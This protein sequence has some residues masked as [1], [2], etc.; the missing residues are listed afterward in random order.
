MS[1]RVAAAVC[2]AAFLSTPAPVSA[3]PKQQPT[4]CSNATYL[5][6]DQR[7]T[8]LDGDD[9]ETP[10]ARFDAPLD[11]VAYVPA[12]GGFW[13]ISGDRVVSFDQTGRITKRA[14]LPTALR[15]RNATSAAA[16]TSDRWIVRTDREVVTYRMPALKE[17]D[18]H[19]LDGPGADILLAPRIAD[20][21]LDH[22]KLYTI[23]SGQLLRIDPRTGAATPI[24][25]PGGLPT[26]GTF[27][28]IVIDPQ[29]TL[30]AWHDQTG[31]R[32]D[33]KLSDPT[34]AKTKASSTPAA[35]ADAAACPEAW[36]YGD[37]RAPYPTSR[38]KN[39][40]RHRITDGLTL[41]RTVT[42]ET[43]AA[44]QDQDD[45]LA[46][47]ATVDPDGKLTVDITVTNQTGHN[48]LLAAWHDLDGNG[49]FDDRDVVTTTVAPGKK[50]RT[51]TL[52]WNAKPGTS[53][54]RIRLYGGPRG[55][56]APSP[57]PTGPAD[58]GEVEDHP[59]IAEPAPAS[60]PKK[61]KLDIQNLA[62]PAAAAPAV[63]DPGAKPEPVPVPF[64]E[65][66]HL[67]VAANARPHEKDRLPL[68]WTVFLGLLV[69]AASV[70][71]RAA[72]KRGS[73]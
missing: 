46:K 24:A 23:A 42:A 30:H 64:P 70:A 33:V 69:P 66:R 59:I 53:T 17:L 11:A 49:R 44:P 41:G 28:A 68:T 8:R 38:A 5:T 51:V 55:Y 48:A 22:G 3:A 63:P 47:P 29:G 6:R 62:G 50:P 21:D 10:I 19:E 25:T 67:P 12:T 45:A 52:R 2:A 72:A 20:W 7:L 56:N 60:E 9:T 39:G 43:D 16:G 61:Q 26:T 4:V 32:Y 35:R 37:A 18:R 73:R 65:R 36:D 71:A 58:S 14:P 31:R 40:P 27:G 57:K 54:L 1:H 15:A 34:T 13:A